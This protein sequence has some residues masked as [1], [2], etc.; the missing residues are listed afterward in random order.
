L[1]A[2]QNILG[3]VKTS[4]DQ[5]YANA[6]DAVQTLDSNASAAG[7]SQQSLAMSALSNDRTWMALAAIAAVGAGYLLLRRKS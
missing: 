5:F 2:L 4:A 7:Q 6:N 1:D 3:G